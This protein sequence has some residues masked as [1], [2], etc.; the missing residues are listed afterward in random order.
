MNE[1]LPGFSLT[2]DDLPVISVAR[3]N[4]SFER[5]VTDGLLGALARRSVPATGFVIGRATRAGNR[6]DE[7]RIA[8]LH[9]W[10]DAGHELGSHTYLHLDLH[11]VARAAF[12]ADVLRGDAALREVLAGWR[13]DPTRVPR[14]FRHPYLDTGLD[15]ATRDAVLDLLASRGLGAV[16][17]TVIP[18]DFVFS[19]AWEWADARDDRATRA[20]VEEAYLAHVEQCVATAQALASRVFGRAIRQIVALHANALNGAALNQVLERLEALG[21]TRPLDETLADP[22]Y[23]TLDGYV[24]DHGVSWLERWALERRIAPSPPVLPPEWV[25]RSARTPWVVRTRR[26]AAHAAH[27]LR[28]ASAVWFRGLRAPSGP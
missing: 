16:P 27:A 19:A 9:R 20:A 13:R 24:K 12:E 8:L 25:R 6:P 15:L 23:R 26:S 11:R 17:A 5:A 28:S 7:R 10:L 14:W 21:P 18:E 1:E 4:S 3:R 2:I 22:A